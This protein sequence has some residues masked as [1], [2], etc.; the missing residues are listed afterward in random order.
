MYYNI[1]L[2]FFFGDKECM[3]AVDVISSTSW[4]PHDGKTYYIVYLSRVLTMYFTGRISFDQ[5]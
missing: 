5:N 1:T 3:A 2:G 4:C